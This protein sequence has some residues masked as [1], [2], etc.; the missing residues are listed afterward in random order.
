[1]K[2]SHILVLVTCFVLSACGEPNPSPQ[3]AADQSSQQTKKKLGFTVEEFDSA[4]KDLYG[5][6]PEEVIKKF[7]KPDGLERDSSGDTTYSYS[8]VE[9]PLTGKIS[10]LTTLLFDKGKLRAALPSHMF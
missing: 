6:S 10:V 9:D 1:M 7:G 3:A 8:G 2:I 5:A 4:A